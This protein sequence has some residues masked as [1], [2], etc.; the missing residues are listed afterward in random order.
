MEHLL[1]FM[2]QG[3]DRQQGSRFSRRAQVVVRDRDR[4][5]QYTRNFAVVV[6]LFLY[7]EE[8]NNNSN[9]SCVLTNPVSS[10]YNRLNTL[11]LRNRL[12]SLSPLCCSL[13]PPH[14]VDGTGAIPSSRSSAVASDAAR[15]GM[16]TDGN[17]LYLYVWLPPLGR[18]NNVSYH[19]SCTYNSPHIF[20]VNWVATMRTCV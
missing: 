18:Q 15:D 4:V 9:V 10:T 11:Y 17:N 1:W 7:R 19:K 16:T 12:L 13:L 20:V 6:E 2:L 3:H 5:H 8:L 14:W